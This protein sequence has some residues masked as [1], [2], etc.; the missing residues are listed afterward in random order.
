MLFEIQFDS[1]P[2]LRPFGMHYVGGK[3]GR[4]VGWPVIIGWEGKI[5]LYCY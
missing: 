4:E 5:I 2:L 3:K 1:D